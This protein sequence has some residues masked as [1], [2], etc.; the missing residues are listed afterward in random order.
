VGP[1]PPDLARSARKLGISEE[2]LR[3]ALGVP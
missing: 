2:Q 1:A 3:D